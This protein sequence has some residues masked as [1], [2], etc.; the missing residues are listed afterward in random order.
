MN[1][2]KML[3]KSLESFTAWAESLLNPEAAYQRALGERNKAMSDFLSEQ[4][5]AAAETLNRSTGIMFDNLAAN[6]KQK[7]ATEVLQ[8][9]KR[10]L[11]KYDYLYDVN[12]N[13]IHP[14][15]EPGRNKTKRDE[16]ISM[17]QDV[18]A[19]PDADAPDYLVAYDDAVK[20]H[21]AI[22]AAGWAI[23]PVEPDDAFWERVKFHNGEHSRSGET[24]PVQRNL[25]R[26]M[27]EASKL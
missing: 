12:G 20:L 7:T 8:Q 23:V 6:P 4:R 14:S 15:C 18:L 17:T 5:K 1:P 2:F 3:G 19:G 27:I 22:E 9:Q 25:H 21:T 16:L 11:G 13:K 10:H 26:A 24:Y